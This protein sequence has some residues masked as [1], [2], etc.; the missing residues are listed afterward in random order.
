MNKAIF[1]YFLDKKT[2]SNNKKANKKKGIIKT[3]RVSFEKKSKK[4]NRQISIQRILDN[5]TPFRRRTKS[6]HFKNVGLPNMI[7]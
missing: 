2:S 4:L 6:S 5:P 1:C 3:V 7:L